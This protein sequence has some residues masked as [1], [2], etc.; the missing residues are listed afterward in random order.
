L[1]LEIDVEHRGTC[2]EG[3]KENR[4]GQDTAGRRQSLLKYGGNKGRNGGLSETIY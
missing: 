4:C 3:S 2:T 1:L